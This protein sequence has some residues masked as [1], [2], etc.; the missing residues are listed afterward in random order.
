[1]HYVIYHINAN[2]L[3]LIK[4]KVVKINP[5]Q[6]EDSISRE[7]NIYEITQ[8]NGKLC[9][10]VTF[11]VSKYLLEMVRFGMQHI[12]HSLKTHMIIQKIN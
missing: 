4:K 1:M 8:K 11:A 12:R 7:K 5:C 6:T 9:D 3:L 2:T 10:F